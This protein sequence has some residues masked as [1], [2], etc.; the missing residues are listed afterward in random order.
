M[1]KKSKNASDKEQVTKKKKKSWQHG[2]QT[3]E[4]RRFH[5][6]CEPDERSWCGPDQGNRCYKHVTKKQLETTW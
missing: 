5:V 2:E 4:C 3:Q 1:S 6:A